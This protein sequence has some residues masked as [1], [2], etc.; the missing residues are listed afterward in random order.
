MIGENFDSSSVPPSRAE[1]AANPDNRYLGVHF[2][3]CGVYSRVYVNRTATEYAGNC[4]KCRRR[5][6]F[7]IGNGGSDSRFFTVY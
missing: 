6:T 3:C 1:D 2:A 5:I 7:R 4:P